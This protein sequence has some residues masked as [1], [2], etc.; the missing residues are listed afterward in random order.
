MSG[1]RSTR[2]VPSMVMVLGRGRRMSSKVRITDQ[3]AA[4]RLRPNRR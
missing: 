1:V 4:A 2:A 3:Q